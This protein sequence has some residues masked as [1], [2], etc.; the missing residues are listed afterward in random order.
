MPPLTV[1]LVARCLESTP[2]APGATWTRPQTPSVYRDLGTHIDLVVLDSRL[3]VHHI[4]NL[5]FSF[6]RSGPVSVLVTTLPCT[7]RLP[8]GTSFLP[9]CVLF[10][11]LLLLVPIFVSHSPRCD[12]GGVGSVLF[13]FVSQGVGPRQRAIDRSQTVERTH[14]DA[15]IITRSSTS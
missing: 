11:I 4:T 12:S 10:D 8:R 13:S 3:P 15:S 6:E 1:F 2:A 14:S 9:N 5:T 7:K